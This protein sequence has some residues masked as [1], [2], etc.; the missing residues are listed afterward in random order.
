MKVR[1]LFLLRL[2]IYYHGDAIPIQVKVKNE[3]NKVVKKI[4]V[5][6]EINRKQLYIYYF[7]IIYIIL[8]FVSLIVLLKI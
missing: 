2:Q 5:T 8:I 4:K 3:T 6:G 1:C 7:I